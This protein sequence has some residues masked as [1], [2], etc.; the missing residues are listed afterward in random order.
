M[1]SISKE[2]EIERAPES[3]LPEWA[4]AIN[5]PK[6]GTR[7]TIGRPEGSELKAEGDLCFDCDRCGASFGS[8]YG[9][10]DL[11]PPGLDN[12]K[13]QE[14]SHY[15]ENVEYYLRMHS[16]WH[17]SPFYRHYHRSFLRLFDPLPPG[18][19]ILECGCGLG[20]DGLE[21][22]RRGHFLVATDISPGQL[23]EARRLHRREGLGRSSLHLLADAENLPFADASFHGV[24][25]V[26]SLHHLS[27]PLKALRE[28]HRVLKPGGI[29]VLG[30]EPNRWQSKTIY[31]VG[32]ALI[33]TVEKLTGVKVLGD[34]MVSEAD[35]KAE[36]FFG[37]ELETLFYRAGFRENRLLPAGYLSAA[38]FFLCTE[39]SQRLPF[40]LK[41]Y[42]LEALLV[43][44]DD[45]L[46]RLP[47]LRKVPWHWNAW[48]RKAP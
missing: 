19:L 12:T 31:P 46:G 18:S 23:R 26:A 42:P 20:H 35:K 21:L 24:L 13:A 14:R 38:L 30:T 7:L 45:W 44:L 22:M 33:K 5:C 4:P 10:P 48:A 36:G 41:L 17:R 2:P 25:M 16:T 40:N 37:R 8:V 3:P 32:K 29:L 34:E 9:L 47:L 43:I 11:T 6:C 27:D 15:T 1:E 39:L 28:A